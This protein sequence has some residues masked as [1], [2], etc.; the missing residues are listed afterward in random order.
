MTKKVE[1]IDF[2]QK[3]NCEAVKPLPVRYLQIEKVQDMCILREAF[4]QGTATLMYGSASEIADFIR[5]I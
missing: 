4:P 2:T 1:K 3:E 5:N